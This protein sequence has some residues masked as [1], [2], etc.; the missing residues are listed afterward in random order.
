MLTLG[1]VLAAGSASAQDIRATVDGT[2]V[3]FTDVQPRMV[4]GRVMVPVRGVFEHMNAH[5]T[6][7]SNSQTVTAIRG[8]DVIKLPL[9][10][11]TA[12]VNGDQ[13][14]LDAPATLYR[15]RTMVPLRF[16]SESLGANVDWIASS[17]TVEISTTGNVP[18]LVTNSAM[19][20]M[21]ARTVIPFSLNRKLSSN[22]STVGDRFTATLETDGAGDYQGMSSGATLEGHVDVARA[23]SGNTPGVLGLKFDRIR[24][25][26]GKTY[27]VVGSLIG[28]D[29]KSVENDNGRLVAKPGAKTNDLKYV[30]YGA[31]AGAL[32]AL[33]TKGNV[34]TTT[35][36]GGALGYLFGEIQKDPSKA[37]DVTLEDGT[38][39]G[40]LLTNGLSFRT[41]ARN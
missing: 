5:V 30:G 27:P 29:E 22:G 7:D 34:V 31:G 35:L 1:A 26:D 21:D 17:R 23:K 16:L 37:R 14:T 19:T 33:I 25:P 41:P 10:S 38:K 13:V 2:M 18:P 32:V 6:W 4:G 20:R 28:L 11:R 40:V 3:N 15:R 12:T 24:M 8:G 39:F 9:H 36:I